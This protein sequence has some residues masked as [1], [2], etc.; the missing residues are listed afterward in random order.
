MAQNDSVLMAPIV[1]TAAVDFPAD[2]AWLSTMKLTEKGS[3][4]ARPALDGPAETVARTLEKW[5]SV[6]A[7]TH[8][9]LGDESIVDGADFYVGEKELGHLHLYSE[10]HIAMPRALRD[11]V[12]AA[13][14]AK[15]FRWSESFVVCRVRTQ[16]DARLAEWLFR[17]AYDRLEGASL[18]SLLKRVD[19]RAH[20]A[21]HD[22]A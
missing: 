6:V 20:R 19:E 10:A 1:I 2:C 18:P 3:F 4:A 22:E 9:Q 5:P 14:L 7:R 13:K 8:W 11:A 12:I 16:T 21:A 17:L 15:P